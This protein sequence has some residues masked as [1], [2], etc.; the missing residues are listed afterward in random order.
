MNEQ[1]E[2]FGT[3]PKEW[4]SEICECC[5][6]EVRYWR[7]RIISTA[8]ASLCRLVYKYDGLTALHH[9]DFTVLQKDRNFSQLVFWNLIYPESNDDDSK[10]S[11]GRWHPTRK[12]IEFVR[13]KTKV[14]SHIVTRLNVFVAFDG[15][16]I[17]IHE[18]LRKRFDYQ[19]LMSDNF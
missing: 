14:R 17:D 16:L 18:A 6:Q 19:V 5:G 8:A 7:K 12:G 4:L 2:L 11:S 1:I 15:P 9:D 3:K 13:F 10:R